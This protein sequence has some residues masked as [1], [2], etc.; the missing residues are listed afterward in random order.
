MIELYERLLKFTRDGVYRYQFSDG[1]ILFANQGLV[2]I[3]DFPGSPDDLRGK[4]LKEVLRYTE[5][6]GSIRDLLEKNGEIHG[7]EYHFK[8]L[9]GKDKWVSHDSFLIDCATTRQKVAEA[10]VKDITERKIAEQILQKEKEQLTVTLRSI[11]DAVITTDT[12]GKISII[13]K[14]AEDLTGWKQPEAFGKPL[15]E[16]FRIVNESTG[17]PCEDPVQKV[18]STG[19]ICGLA[20]NTILISRTG[21]KRIIADSGAPILDA[22]SNILGVVLVFRDV[23]AVRKLEVELQKTHRLES[24]S[25]LASGIAHDFNN[26]LT[27]IF[28]YIGLAQLEVPPSSRVYN[29]LA[30]AERAISRARDL[31]SQLLTFSRRRTPQ[32]KV[33]S[34]Q[35]LLMSEVEFAL[36]GSTVSCSFSIP[37]NLGLVEIDEV[38][39]SQVIHNLVI[40][41]VQAMPNGGNIYVAGENI[42]ID[43]KASIP[44]SRGNYIK[45]SLKDEG[46]GIPQDHLIK[47]FDPYFTTKQQ[48]SGLGLSI[49]YSNIKN[50]GGLLTVEAEI[51]KGATFHFYL[52]MSTL[53]KVSEME[54]N[55]PLEMGNGKILVMDDDVL[56]R[57]SLEEMLTKLG[58]EV[59][60]SC[61]GGEAVE[62]F[63][64]AQSLGK[65]FRIAIL[66]LTIPG[67]MGALE[68]MRKLVEM[69]PQIKAIISSGYPLNDV[70]QE[71]Q[72]YGFAGVLEKPF[73]LKMLGETLSAVLKKKS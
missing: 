15:P 54:P 59:E 18:L 35:Q 69:D 57:N 42:L 51:G 1:K 10:V 48:G 68:T 16:V 3:L 23:T 28:G 58:Y 20:N 34:M 33:V 67:G 14:V 29:R 44:L 4:L 46:I 45:I 56:V 49:A 47:I 30:N 5:K 52:P 6:E 19:N 36:R 32:K 61:H 53:A 17:R 72:R 27:G 66:D 13:N 21:E 31:S 8:T 62:K 25:L 43:D 39:I 65:S 2:D 60:T 41:A 73:K 40:N 9:S 22:N 55:M 70:M 63:R 7:F 71:F 38:Q 64:H 26:I 11:G 12:A 37:G 24:I 50:H